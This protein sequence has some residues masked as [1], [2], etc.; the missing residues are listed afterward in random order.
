MFD[1]DG[2]VRDAVD[3]QDGFT[4]GVNV[5]MWVVEGEGDVNFEMGNFI[6]FAGIWFDVE[7]RGSIFISI[8]NRVF[9]S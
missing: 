4:T 5:G 3:V 1:V 9:N 7:M 8:I 2:R 6:V